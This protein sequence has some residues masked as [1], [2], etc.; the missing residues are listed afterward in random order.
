MRIY[1]N[2]KSTSENRLNAR[3]WYI[4]EGSCKQ[5]M[6]NGEWRFAFF[7]NGDRAGNIEEWETIEVPSCWQLKGYENPNYTNINYPF[8]CDPPY[9]P[10]INPTGVYERSFQI[11]DGS[12]ETYF[13]FEGVSSEAELYINGKYVGRTQGSRLTAEFD[14]TE[15]VSSGTNTARVY[16]RKWCCGSYLEDQ[17]AFRYNGIFRDVYVLSRPHGHIFDIDIKTEENDIICIADAEFSAELYDRDALLERRDSVGGKAVFTV[18]EPSLWTAETPYLYTVKLYAAGEIITRKIGFRTIKI[19]SDYELLINGTP[20]KLK[21]VNHHDTDPYKGWTMSE[22]DYVRDLKLMKEL[23]INTVRTSHYPPAPKFL[24]YCDEMGFYVI[25]EC[26][27]E[28]HGFVRRYA[29]IGYKFD[30]ENG[31][32]PC[33]EEM[34]KKEFLDRIE[35]TYER[36]KIHTS[37]IMWSTGNESAYGVNQA[38]QIDWLKA[39][40]KVR[41]AHCEDASRAGSQEKTDVFSM[42]YPVVEKLCEWAKDDNIRQP[43]FMCEYAHAMGNGPGGMWDY[44]NA[45]Y[46]NKKLI[47]GCIWEWADHTVMVD[48]VA[49][50]GG[51]FEGELTHDGNF[52]CDG[53]VFADR[54]LKSGS[55]EVK[56]A[57]A[58]FRIKWEN[59][60]LKLKNCFDF[61]SFDGYT[62]EYNITADGESL[63]KRIVRVNT[64]P[65]DK[66]TIIPA[67]SV[68]K[69]C[70]LGCFATVSMKDKNGFELGILEEKIPVKIERREVTGTALNVTESEFDITAEGE[71]FKY[72]LSKQTGTFTS[73]IKNGGELLT[74]PMKLSYFRATTDNDRNM[75]PLWDRTNIWQGENFDCAFNKVYSYRISGNRAE[76]TMS[77]AGVS[78]KPFFNYTLCYEFFADGKVSVSLDGKI[79]EKVVWL[80]RLGFEFKLP[81]DT[82]KFRYFG[83]GPMDSYRDMTHHGITAWHESD[84]DREYVSYIRPQ[85][86]G[87]HYGC[88]ELE[89]ENSLK[90]SAE[91]LMEISV[92]HHSIEQL[93]KAEHTDEL[94]KSDGTHIRIDYKVSGIGSNSCGPQLPE[95]YQLCEKDIFFKFNISL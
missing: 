37:I 88:R 48:G 42:M 92:L 70:R 40:D 33:V 90:F 22:E 36:D 69:S 95:K 54:S 63:E 78:R 81:Y 12:L 18:N 62:F 23:N 4:P 14:I 55:Y 67:V 51:D 32:W 43:V 89:I 58:P 5:I 65:G 38:A 3:S 94:K 49:K 53:M 35:R 41:L 61:T 24:D 44:W 82:S 77:A 31:D 68:P 60:V 56:N 84:A 57:Y 64:K 8:P 59:G 86:H 7:E 6:L 29:N 66:F 87:N 2:P 45:I 83:N 72:V 93:T 9:V 13:V 15:F 10:D 47:G 74:A 1:E 50:Y 11:E 25:L 16:V 39:R 46:E 52:C 73:I 30:T 27:I 85:E 76:F 79:R 75:K 80:P 28:T 34:W 21:G 20:V 19:S 71:G 91:D 17:D 26:D